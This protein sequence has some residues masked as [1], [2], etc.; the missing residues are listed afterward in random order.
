M[1]GVLDLSELFHVLQQKRLFA[2]YWV[3]RLNLLC[4]DNSSRLVVVLN[5]DLTGAGS[6]GQ[7]VNLKK[8]KC[9]T[10]SS[11]SGNV[12]VVKTINFLIPLM[13]NYVES[14][15]LAL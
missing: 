14:M 2:G 5:Y 6:N 11:V 15:F 1:S 8:Y 9:C 13:T 3:A 4:Y 12:N 10:C 7:A